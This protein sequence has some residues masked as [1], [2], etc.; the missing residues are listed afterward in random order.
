MENESTS[1][2][3]ILKPSCLSF[4]TYQ[5]GKTK[6]VCKCYFGTEGIYPRLLLSHNNYKTKGQRVEKSS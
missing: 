5:N 2:W 4:Y 3:T 1:Q 6:Y